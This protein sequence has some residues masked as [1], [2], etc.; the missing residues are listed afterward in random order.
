MGAW[1]RDPAR[2]ISGSLVSA[3]LATT[4]SYLTFL[5]SVSIPKEFV[6]Y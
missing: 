5:P 6:S 1:L 4:I 2:F 3:T